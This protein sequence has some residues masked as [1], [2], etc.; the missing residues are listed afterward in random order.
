M[1]SKEQTEALKIYCNC[2]QSAKKRLELIEGITSRR[3]R[4][5]HESIEAEFACL[6]LRKTLELIAFASVAARKDVYSQAHA[7]FASHWNAKKLMAKLEKLHPDFYPTPAA[8][9]APDARGVKKLVPQR[10]PHKTRQ[11]SR[12]R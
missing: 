5:D 8:V 2:L 12:C 11:F 4:I 6:Q 7:D 10:W 3:L 9:T 1:P